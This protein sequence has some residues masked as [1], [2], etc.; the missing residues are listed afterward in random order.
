[1]RINIFVAAAIAAVLPSTPVRAADPGCE[2]PQLVSTGGPAPQKAHTLAIR[3][4]GYSNFELAYGGQIL[5][6]DAYFDRGGTYPPLGFKSADIARA[7]AI[8]IGHAHFDHMSDAASVAARTGAVVVGAPITTDKLRSQNLAEKQIRTVSGKGGETLKIGKFQVEPILGRHG[9]PPPE[10][11]RA[12]NQA[13]RSVA[14]PVSPEEAAASSVIRARGSSDPR[15]IGEGTIAYLITLDDGFRIMYRDSGG[16]VTDYERAAMQRVGRVDIAVAA[17]AADVLD[18]LTS[19]RALEYLR[20]YKPAVYIPAHHD[21]DRN[22]MWRPTEPVF[23]ALKEE[24]PK[25]LT[26]SRQYREPMCFDTEN[27]IQRGKRK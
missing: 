15:I 27:N 5:L 17:V 24:D 19:R 13:L 14:T 20:T 26:I 3:W 1:M 12:F 25:L 11:T 10:V 22:G 21:A 4:T 7:D 6:L 9:E 2:A 16:S 18:S 23:Q 8:L